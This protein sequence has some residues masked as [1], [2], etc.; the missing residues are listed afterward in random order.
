MKLE[1]IHETQHYLAINKPHGLSVHN[2]DQH[3]SSVLQIL[4]KGLHLAHRL[5]KET[6]GIL[7]LAKSPKIAG[8]LMSALQESETKKTYRC[9]L[10]G[11]IRES[12]TPEG[13]YVWSWPLTDKAEG[14][15]N[16]QGKNVDRVSAQTKITVL[17]KN[18]FFTEVQAQILTGRQHQIRKHA[19]LA[20]HPIV[21]DPRYN[22]RK[23]NN[24]IFSIYNFERMLLH[25]ESLA[26]LFLNE[27]VALEAP[28][29]EI[30][31]TFFIERSSDS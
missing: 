25:A 16:P 9:I 30:F 26:F 15:D 1:I 6:S 24:K 10:R 13:S 3:V 20:K 29:P 11:T 31:K 23:Y 2:E 4:G 22:D 17:Q 8:L 21:G 14:R 18:T 12:M 27:P 28:V 19:A 5:D 7:L